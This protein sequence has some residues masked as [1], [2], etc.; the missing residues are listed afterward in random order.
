MPADARPLIALLRNVHAN[1]GDEAMLEC[2]IAALRDLGARLVVLTDD[3]EA[4]SSRYAVQAE[5]SD[6]CLLNPWH[7]KATR[8]ADRAAWSFPPLARLARGARHRFV[9]PHQCNRFLLGADLPGAQARL[10]AILDEAQVIVSGGG[11]IPSVPHMERIRTTVLEAAH[12]KGTPVIFSGQTIYRRGDSAAPYRFGTHL[13]TRDSRSRDNAISCGFPE[14]RIVDGVDPAFLLPAAPEAETSDLLARY[15]L[16]GVRFA[17]VNVRSGVTLAAMEGLAQMLE[18]L[19][20][21]GRFERILAFGMQDH[22]A[23]L[24][25]R[26][27]RAL[28]A[29]PR[30]AGVMTRW[31]SPG[32]LKGV[33]ARADF[34]ATC[35]YHAAVFA[36]TSA[37]PVMA[38]SISPEYDLKLRGILD[39]FGRQDWL[40]PVSAGASLAGARGDW[41][42]PGTAAALAASAASLARRTSRLIETVEVALGARHF[43]HH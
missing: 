32:V 13:V 11:L 25:A 18:S 31:P 19:A 33:L 12:A 22:S 5:Y 27:V 17:A 9:L 29:N 20:R 39:Q 2:E 1:L 35:R 21:E 16:G 3:P 14:A 43:H 8:V 15:G 24:D 6:V 26:W 37:R 40:F 7:G 34:V 42:D 23:E 38:L 41:F 10:R 36:L 28:R 4:V 30:V